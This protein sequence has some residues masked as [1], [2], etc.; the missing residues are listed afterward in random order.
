MRIPKP[1]RGLLLVLL[2]GLGVGGWLGWR[3]W[4]T[5]VPPQ[6]RLDGVQKEVAQAVEAALEEVRQDPRSGAA[7]GKL[8]MVLHVNNFNEHVN[9][10]YRQAERFEPKDPRWPYLH[11]VRLLDSDRPQAIVLIRQALGR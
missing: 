7:W 11:G 8:A 3:W 5:P 4:T 1:G 10:C 9:D 6:V 2:L